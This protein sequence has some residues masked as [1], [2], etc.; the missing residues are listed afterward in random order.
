MNYDV[1]VQIGLIGFASGFFVGLFAQMLAMLIK[2]IYKI[3]K[4][5]F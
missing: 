4:G 3:F 1:L 2:Y 5:G